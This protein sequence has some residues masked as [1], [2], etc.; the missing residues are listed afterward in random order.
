MPRILLI[1]SLLFL[2]G[3]ARPLSNGETAFARTIFGDD[4]ATRRVRVA[5]FVALDRITSKR[6]V[7]PRTTCREKIWPPP[8]G[9]TVTTATA[10]FVLWNRINISRDLYHRDYMARYPRAMSLP[11]AMLIAHELTHVWQWQHRG[12][13]GYTPLKAAREHRAGKDPYLLNLKARRRFLD[14]PYEQQASI[15][16]EYVCCRALDPG[17]ARTSR[18][19]AMLSGV[20]PLESLA[21]PANRPAVFLPWKQARTRGICS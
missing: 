14:F 17:G 1:L 21:H 6:P 2:A 20:F 7:R 3:C 5:P 8:K 16:E 10:A 15:V 13:T 19:H 11:A 18:L 12:Q 9:E 4:L